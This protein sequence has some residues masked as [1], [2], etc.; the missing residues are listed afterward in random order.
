MT[1]FSRA[2]LEREAREWAGGRVSAG[3]RGNSTRARTGV[4]GEAAPLPPAIRPAL[5][6]MFFR[7]SEGARSGAPTRCC[8]L[9]KLL[10][11]L[12]AR[13]MGQNMMRI[14]CQDTPTTNHSGLYT[15]S[16]GFYFWPVSYGQ[17][18]PS[19]FTGRKVFEDDTGSL[20]TLLTS[21]YSSYRIPKHYGE[22]HSM[23]S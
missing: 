18:L 9:P 11:E 14:K 22:R 10:D 15:A 20:L 1:L 7:C 13:P 6:I 12:I 16:G 21:K 8:R 2:P 3:G 23:P 19:L 17:G 5:G 4:R